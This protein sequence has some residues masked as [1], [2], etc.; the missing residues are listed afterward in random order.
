MKLILQKEVDKLGVPGDVVDVADGY[1]RNFLVPRGMAI[2]ASK[3]A[4]KNAE[5]LRSG[6]EAKVGKAKAEAEAVSARLTA[7]T[8]RIAAKAGEPWYDDAIAWLRRSE[9]PSASCPS[10]PCARCGARSRPR[11]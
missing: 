10:S 3:G 4:V 6:H 8:V 1:A 5:R 9:L 11:T 7:A 2:A